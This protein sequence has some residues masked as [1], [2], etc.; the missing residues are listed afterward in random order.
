[1]NFEKTKEYYEQLI[2]SDLCQCS[3]CKNYIKEIRKSYPLVA[4]YLENMGVDIEK[5][6]EAMTLES[7]KKQNIE[8]ISVQYFVIGDRGDFKKA[9]ISGV[10][11]DIAESHPSTDIKDNHFVIEIFPIILKWVI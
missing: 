9:M 5:P 11:I 10:N 2:S 3:Y 4:K 8:Y 6:L 1:M 7:D